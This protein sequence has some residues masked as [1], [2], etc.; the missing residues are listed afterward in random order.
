MSFL[1]DIKRHG[2]I[3]NHE[4]IGEATDAYVTSPNLISTARGV[5][6]LILG[7]FMMKN[8]VSPENAA[9]WSMALAASDMEGSLIRVSKNHPNLQRLLLLKASK[10]G[11]R[12]D[13]IF[14]KMCMAATFIGGLIGG[15]LPSYTAGLLAGEAATVVSSGRARQ[16]T[17]QDPEIGRVGKTGQ[18]LRFIVAPAF[19]FQK[20]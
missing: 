2:I 14:D 1:D 12:L 19:Y 9:Y 18:I 5:G 15:Q 20:Q 11:E 6:G 10:I 4:N 7:Y 16:N 13:P 17:G 3:T 8:E